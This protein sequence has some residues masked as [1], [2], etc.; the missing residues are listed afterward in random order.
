MR[1]AFLFLLFLPLCLAAQSGEVLPDTAYWEG[2][3][4][5][6]YL[7][8]E[9]SYED[10]GYTRQRR[11]VGD[12]AAAKNL[13]LVYAVQGGPENLPS[14]QRVAAG[15]KEY[16]QRGAA[17]Q[18]FTRFQPLYTQ[19]TGEAYAVWAG[20]FYANDLVG[21]YRLVG[22]GSPYDVEIFQLTAGPNA[23]ALRCRRVDDQ[24][25]LP[26]VTFIGDH[27]RL[28]LAGT[29]Y[30]FWAMPKLQGRR[31]FLTL[32]FSRRLIQLPVQ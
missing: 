23:G 16:L 17:M 14:I 26:L 21:R 4:D 7:V 29:V 30:E 13:A 18:I 24:T 28:N 20:K 32:D 9:W 1:Y 27:F 12:T 3:G 15:A 5:S 19:L 8:T 11:F 10:G 25:I 2:S 31:I 6:L 22:D